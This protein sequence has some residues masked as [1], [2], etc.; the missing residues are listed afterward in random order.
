MVLALVI[1]LGLL[2]APFVTVGTAVGFWLGGPVGAAVGFV[3]GLVAG[4]DI[5]D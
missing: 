1:A 5:A 3:I 4:S 2:F